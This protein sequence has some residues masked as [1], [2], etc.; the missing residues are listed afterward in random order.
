[1][2]CPIRPR[3]PNSKSVSSCFHF[4]QSTSSFKIPITLTSRDKT[5]CTNA[6][7]DSGAAGNFISAE[8]AQQHN[9]KLTPCDSQLAVEALD[10]RPLGGGRIAHLTEEIHMQIGALHHENIRF[11]IILSPN[12]PV[13]L[14]LPWF[15]SHNPHI[16]WREGQIIH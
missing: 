8:F 2:S 10:G 7:L 3:N 14:S 15:R 13:I 9:F 16:S 6:L 1:M 4:S 11:Y 12:N 5:I